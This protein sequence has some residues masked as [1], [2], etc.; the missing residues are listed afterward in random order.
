LG[1]LAWPEGKEATI[2]TGKSRVII[3]VEVVTNHVQREEEVVVDLRI[4]VEEDLVTTNPEEALDAP[5]VALLTT[6]HT[7]NNNNS[8]PLIIVVVDTKEASNNKTQ[9]EVT[10]EEEEAIEVDLQVATVQSLAANLRKCLTLSLGLK[11]SSL[12]ITTN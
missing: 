2:M 8:N 11:L 3:E 5:T 7:H 12:A 9:E 10:T 4:E 6:N 1:T